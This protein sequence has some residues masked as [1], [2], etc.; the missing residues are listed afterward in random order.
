MHTEEKFIKSAEEN[1]KNSFKVGPV[2]EG[3]L[4]KFMD[5]KSFLR[6]KNKANLTGPQTT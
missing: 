1:N 4:R 3:P 5:S 2:A 6:I